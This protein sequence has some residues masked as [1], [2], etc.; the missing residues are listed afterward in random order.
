MTAADEPRARLFVALDLPAAA[1]DALTEW[2]AE[3]LAGR[4][5]ELRAVAPEAL[6]IT[7]AFIGSR[8]EGEIEA[9]GEALADAAGGLVAPRLEPKGVN[10]IPPR[11][12]RLFA[13]DL[14]DP[15]GAA[16]ALQAKVSEALEGGGF[17]KPE[18]RPFWP[19]VTVARVKKGAHVRRAPSP[20]PAAEPFVAREVVLY[21]SRLHP[22]G[23][24][25]EPL[26]CLTLAPRRS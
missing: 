10:P 14:A 17:Y 18:E 21:R 19:H 12:P 22:H 2:Q 4:D 13:V 25:Y 15:D 11:R 23:A 24:R 6:H 8:P 20:P 26:I 1:R 5:A 16:T 3:A 9:I 7:L